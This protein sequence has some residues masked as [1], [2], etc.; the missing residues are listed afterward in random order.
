MNADFNSTAYRK[1]LAALLERGYRVRGFEDVDPQSRDLILRH[2]ID[3]L[4]GAALPIAEI[5][6]T[7]GVRAHYFVLVRTEMYNL[8]SNRARECLQR[9]R[10]LGHHIGLHLDASLYDNDLVKLQDA[11]AHECAVLEQATGVPVRTVSFHRP[12]KCL[13]GYPDKLAGRLHAYQPRFFAE[14]GYCSD[15]RGAW[16][17]GHPLEHSA[18]HQGRALQLLTHP[19]WWIDNVS[20]PIDK[21]KSVLSARV[22]TIDRE[23]ARNSDIYMSSGES[24]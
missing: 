21:L 3:V 5:E 16:H 8:F 4:L 14:M 15:S 1:L 9:L 24:P 13:L 17:Y 19:I 23:L 22:A 12:A 18:V 11:A 6:R 2:D 7:Y 20:T 10:A